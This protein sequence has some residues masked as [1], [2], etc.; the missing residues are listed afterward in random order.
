MEWEIEE[1]CSI[2]RAANYTIVA[3]QWGKSPELWAVY[4]SD[5]RGPI[6][7]VGNRK[8]EAL[9]SREE[10]ETTAVDLML[11]HISDL[12]AIIGYKVVKEQE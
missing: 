3:D 7:Q 10:A 8:S 9:K 2:L 5:V 6:V 4:I 12:A 1:G 11:K